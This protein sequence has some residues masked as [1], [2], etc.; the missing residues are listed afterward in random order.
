MYY[1]FS[2]HIILNTFKDYQWFGSITHLINYRKWYMY[3]LSPFLVGLVSPPPGGFRPS[4]TRW[5]RG[6]WTCRRPSGA[7]P[8]VPPVWGCYRSRTWPP[9]WGSPPVDVSSAWT[10]RAPP[11][12]AWDTSRAQTYSRPNGP[13]KDLTLFNCTLFRHIGCLFVYIIICIF[14]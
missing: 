9:F 1:N 4:Y 10:S 8:P 3:I 6:W 12:S 14:N 13:V 5:G 11:R 2:F 7:T